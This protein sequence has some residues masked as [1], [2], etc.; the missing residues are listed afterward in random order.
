MAIRDLTRMKRHVLICNGGSCMKH[1]GEKVTECLRK[2]ITECN[3]DSE[4]HTT[5]T[6]C[7]GR[8]D[9]GPIVVVYPDGI[10]YKY[11]NEK[12]AQKIVKKHLVKDREVADSIL[13]DAASNTINDS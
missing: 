5:K 1:G 9:D 12:T 8:C 3:I 6:R 10:W 2:T 4:V 13:Y 7:L 11:V